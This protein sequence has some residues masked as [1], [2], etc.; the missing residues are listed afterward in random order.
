MLLGDMIGA[1]GPTFAP[2]DVKVVGDRQRVLCE[3]ANT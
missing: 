3:G 2:Q 1:A